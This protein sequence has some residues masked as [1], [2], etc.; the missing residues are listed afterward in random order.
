MREACVK[1]VED[2]LGRGLHPGEA[3][4]IEDRINKWHRLL[5]RRN[6]EA[7][8]AMGKSA[9]LS[10]A[11]KAAAG[12]LIGDIVK[13]RQRVQLATLAWDRM[14]NTL[15]DFDPKDPTARL[16]AL[17]RVYAWD[18]AKGASGSIESQAQGLRNLYTGHMIDAF[19]AAEPKLLGLIQSKKGIADLIREIHG[20]DT[21]NA[22]AKSGAAAWKKVADEMRDR[23][24]AAGGDVGKLGE[25]YFP[26]HHDRYRV[27]NAG[28]QRWYKDTEPLLDKG[29]YLREDGSRM[30]PDE[31]KD[32]FGH[33]FDTI[34]NDGKNKGE[35]RQT[36][37]IGPQM[38]DGSGRGYGLY[39][40]RN[41]QHRQVFFKDGDSFL[42]YQSDYGHS[43]HFATM[44]GH[45]SR[46]TRDIAVLE[47]LGPWADQMHETWNTREAVDARRATPD[48][49]NVKKIDAQEYR[50]SVLYDHIVGSRDNPETWL[51]RA[52]VAF[53]NVMTGLRLGKVAITAL[54]DE[55]GMAATSWANR[56]PY[57]RTM[58]EE[59]RM[60]NPADHTQ[61]RVMESLGL[62]TNS[63]LGAVNR[64]ADESMGAGW[65][66]RFG[67]WVMRATGAERLWDARRQGLASVLMRQIGD[68]TRKFE[69]FADINER[70]HGML[71][72][73]GVDESTWS[74]WRAAT[75]D[76]DGRITPKEIDQIPDDR[77]KDIGDPKTLKRNAQTAIM[78]HV[79]EETGMGV[80]EIGARQRS[81]ISAATLGASDNPVGRSILLFKT[82]SMAMMLKHWTRMASLQGLS[83]KVGYG[84]ALT[85]YGTAIAA[86][87][88][89]I[90]LLLSGQNR[91]PMNDKKFWA[92][93][94][95][96]GG[97]LGYMGDFLYDE[98]NSRDQNIAEALGGPLE[99]E[100]QDAWNVT[101]KPMLQAYNGQRT[102]EA[103][104]LIK[105]G[106]DHTPVAN[107][108]YT[109]A[110]FDHILWFQMQEASNPGYLDR[111][112][113]RQQK[114]NR[115]YWWNPHDRVPTQGPDITEAH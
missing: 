12:E 67:N 37:M 11:A 40:D 75:P 94:V 79:Y 48:E 5:G 114:Y 32:F 65:T 43:S 42:R 4:G 2:V 20:Q 59:M 83:A 9:R 8:R 84:A 80:M 41:S 95:L 28:F 92:G 98:L 38:L 74:T 16:R 81:A 68:H 51:T 55:A 73:K 107:F 105:W 1:A 39:A 30:Q 24:N 85:V 115:S 49:A 56:I 22:V 66:G 111:M 90:R 35:K 46:M 27:G 113:Q 31:L 54:G 110:A 18:P 34:I 71:A 36:D 21:G 89:Q 64:F 91:Q 52:N 99:G 6:D 86:L 58:L 76:A 25:Q 78:A 77:L 103:A 63:M 102:E 97:G 108:W 47:K 53:R 101:G 93:A 17:S 26:N 109:Q 112:M 29:K 70:D 69:H 33:V 60:L 19:K 50:N 82:F 87:G 14:E 23:I 88:N 15:P 62:G 104:N 44:L 57:S 13:Q 106:R 45:V 61:R 72:R 10:A 96:R 7:W 3:R 100:I